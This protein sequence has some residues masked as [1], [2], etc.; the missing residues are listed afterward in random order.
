MAYRNEAGAIRKLRRSFL[1]PGYRL[2]RNIGKFKR[3][4]S[5][6]C[7]SSR[8]PPGRRSIQRYGMGRRQMSDQRR[9]LH[10]YRTFALEGAAPEQVVALDRGLVGER[11]KR[12]LDHQGRHRG[13]ALALQ[14]RLVLPQEDFDRISGPG[15]MRRLDS[16]ICRIAIAAWCPCRQALCSGIRRAF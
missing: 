7:G 5:A 4:F 16:R 9:D 3:N 8:A 12:G 6:F 2:P 10:S 13:I 14:L 1:I 15:A 11:F